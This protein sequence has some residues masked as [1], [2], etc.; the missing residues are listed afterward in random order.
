[1]RLPAAVTFKAEMHEKASQS[2]A[3]DSEAGELALSQARARNVDQIS[4]WAAPDGHIL[5]TLANHG[6]LDFTLNWV[7]TVSRAG[8]QHFFVATLDDK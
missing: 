1:M 3:P 7:A 4:A 6:W 2:A 5:W 8:V